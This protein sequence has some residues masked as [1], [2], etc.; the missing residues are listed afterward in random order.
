MRPKQHQKSKKRIK[1]RVKERTLPSR[2][3]RC[4]QVPSYF[5]VFGSLTL[6]GVVCDVTLFCFCFLILSFI[7]VV[8]IWLKIEFSPYDSYLY[9]TCGYKM[10][11]CQMW[12]VY[13]LTQG[14]SKVWGTAQ[15]LD[16]FGDPPKWWWSPLF[17]YFKCLYRHLMSPLL[18]WQRCV[19]CLLSP[20]NY[21]PSFPFSIQAIIKYIFIF[22]NWTYFI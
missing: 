21:N 20:F 9:C 17:Y 2:S 1:S 3:A 13:F 19:V 5:R 10:S 16:F 11:S 18:R 7:K 22:M 14:V 12:T 6:G 15:H 8:E 4:W